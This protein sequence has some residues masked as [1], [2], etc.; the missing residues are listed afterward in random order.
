M[1]GARSVRRVWIPAFPRRSRTGGVGAPAARKARGAP[2]TR[3]TPLGA[4]A[5]ARPRGPW[6]GR[7]APRA[8]ASA[9]ARGFP[10]ARRLRWATGAAARRGALRAGALFPAAP[11]RRYGHRRREGRRSR[12]WNPEGG[13]ASAPTTGPAAPPGWCATPSAPGVEAAVCKREGHRGADGCAYHEPLRC[14]RRGR[15][16]QAASAQ[17]CAPAI[18]ARLL[19]AAPLPARRVGRRSRATRPGTA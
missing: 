9:Q 4:E 3:N 2:G 19:P 12:R 11:S 1:R 10:S 14:P 5:W 7:A 18:P 8:R 13:G 15:A 17:I 16:T 6:Q